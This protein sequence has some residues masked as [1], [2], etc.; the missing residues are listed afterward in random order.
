M[1]LILICTGMGMIGSR[2]FKRSSSESISS[3]GLVLINID[4]QV[5]VYIRIYMSYIHFMPMDLDFE[6][7]NIPTNLH[8]AHKE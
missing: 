5:Y 6:K 1:W 8:I 4:K 7:C 3:L 2:V